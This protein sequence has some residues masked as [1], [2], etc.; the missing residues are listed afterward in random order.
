V[1]DF[2]RLPQQD[3]AYQAWLLRHS[4]NAFYQAALG[5]TS[6]RQT[7]R[8]RAFGDG[9]AYRVIYHHLSIRVANSLRLHYRLDFV[10]L[11]KSGAQYSQ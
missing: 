10:P 8:Y 5:L 7:D 4:V 1:N 2:A 9:F 6:L 11:L 3:G